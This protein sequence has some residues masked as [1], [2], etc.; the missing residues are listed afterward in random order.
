MDECKEGKTVMMSH[1]IL[2]VFSA[3]ML[4]FAL[5]PAFAQEQTGTL[6][7]F[8]KNESNDRAPPENTFVKIYQDQN[9]VPYQTLDPLESNPFKTSLPMGHSYKVEV[10]VDSIYAGVAFANMNQNQ[11][12]LD[13]PIRN[14][15]G[16]R[17]T[18]YYSDGYTPFPNVQVLIKSPDGK[19]WGSSDTDENG[20]T[21]RSWLQS[22][23]RQ[24]DHYY[25]EIV[26]GPKLKYVFS[27]LNIQPNVSQ[28]V[29]V[30]TNWP[31][32]VDKLITVEVYNSTKNKVTM[33]DGSFVAQL[34]DAK[35]KMTAE[36]AVTDKGVAH[37]S[38]LKV[39]TYT[40]YVKEKDASGNLNLLVAKKVT[41]TNSIDT[42]KIY[43]NNPSLNSDN[44]VCNCVAFRLDDI[45]DYYLAPAQREIISMF[46]KRDVPLTIGV[47]GGVTGADPNLVSAIKGGLEAKHPIEVASHSWNNRV[48]T[49]LSKTEQAELIK[50]TNDK[51]KT[52]F[53]VE[54]TTFIPPEN[55]FNAD[56]LDI[57]KSNNFTHISYSVATKDPP[58]FKKSSFYHFPTAA[59]SSIL[60]PSTGF[61]KPQSVQQIHDAIEG[62]M[63]D[64]GYA[65]VMMHPY[66]FSNYEN[67]FYTNNVNS[68]R[69]QQMG[70]LID[71]LQ[72]E[73][74][75]IL[76][77]G[78]IEDYDKIEKPSVAPVSE[79]SQKVGPPNCNCVAFRIDNVQDYYLNDVQNMVI[80][81]FDEKRTP[82]TIGVIGKFFGSDPKT[83]NFIKDKVANGTIDMA[84]RGWEY[85][86]HTGYSVDKQSASI[87]QTNDK[88]YTSLHVKADIF[89][90][91]MDLFNKDT[92][93]AVKQ[94]K[95]QYF[96][97]T[98]SADTPAFSE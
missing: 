10:Y 53:G 52:V 25:A 45:Q 93:Q 70:S 39:G 12:K 28:E 87:M 37:F 88:I 5:Y 19:L 78:S 46:E 8:I 71:E 60:D 31:K 47:I 34:F 96:S 79:P 77:I 85:V 11:V 14:S 84:N 67:G 72:S 57:L 55:L 58:P 38:N 49:S 63:L 23:I 69:V 4:L 80:G 26:L 50:K 68:T 64:Y 83:V 51:I 65:V 73:N 30:V 44:L 76:Q 59:A 22:T 13:I 33:Q 92:V 91:P 32:L 41:V 6:E 18:V 89:S 90:P 3:A 81:K 20:Q 36:S 35:K 86:D 27:P 66:E 94:N 97:S 75:K 74:Y 62:S 21:I 42:I 61:W 82:V 9:T 7:V 2:L 16:I 43:I 56:T 1:N 48:L 40:I 29:K 24:D 15:G 98:I 17:L 95:M 54:P